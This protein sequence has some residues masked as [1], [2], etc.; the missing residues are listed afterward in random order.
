[1][2][3]PRQIYIPSDIF[4]LLFLKQNNS[5]FC[6]FRFMKSVVTLRAHTAHQEGSAEEEG[7]EEGE[8]EKGAQGGVK[9]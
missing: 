8:L 9:D 3:M 6:V 2:N 5:K 1:M 4:G 7:V